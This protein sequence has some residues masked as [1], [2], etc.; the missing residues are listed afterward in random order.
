MKPWVWSFFE[1]TFYE[2]HV[3]SSCFG[4]HFES[5]VK[6]LGSPLAIPKNYE[7]IVGSQMGYAFGTCRPKSHINLC[8]ASLVHPSLVGHT[9]K[10][11]FYNPTPLFEYD[12]LS[13]M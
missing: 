2:E 10:P 6:H 3:S 9:R 8:N 7:R 12:I 4:A 5:W 1:K 13:I 11:D